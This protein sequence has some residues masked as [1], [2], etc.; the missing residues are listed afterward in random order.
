MKISKIN[1]Q[2]VKCFDTYELSLI[3]P[4]S[5]EPLSVCA[6]VG[7]NGS[8]KS[9]ILKSI[10]A[11]FTTLYPEYNGELFK[12][13][14]LRIG[15]HFLSSE[16]EF[17]LSKEELEDFGVEN[18]VNR[19]RYIHEEMEKANDEPRDYLAF[20]EGL[21]NRTKKIESGYIK[22]L[23][24]LLTYDNSLLIYFDPFRFM[25]NKVPAGPN[26]E[27]VISSARKNALSS[28]INYDGNVSN[29]DFNLKQWF[30]NLDYKLLKEPND[31]NKQ[32]FTHVIKSFELLLK[33][34]LFKGINQNGNL[35]FIDNKKEEEIEIDML[36]D[37]FKSIFLIISEIIL[38]LSVLSK[39]KLFYLHE[40]VILIDEIDCHIH[41]RWQRTLVPSLRT[42]FPNCQ[43]IITT[44]SPFILESLQ[45]YEIF[46]VGEKNII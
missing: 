26:N 37:G 2:N 21:G 12:D 10:V 7:T 30:V 33:P 9:T 32:I 11:S 1:L 35:T 31:T 46:K 38:R 41:P 39:D 19:I 4:D 43:F 20:P 14:T 40:A 3:K 28:N 8:G 18:P 45:E 13:C 36:S 34:L 42:L 22:F 25:T 23:Q 27:S 5:N 44:H 29:R 16:I 15:E 24:T 6:L 17:I